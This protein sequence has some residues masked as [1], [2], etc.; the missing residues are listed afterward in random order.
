MLYISNALENYILNK[1][2]AVY[3]Q[4]TSKLYTE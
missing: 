4:C 1:I 2:I 3:K